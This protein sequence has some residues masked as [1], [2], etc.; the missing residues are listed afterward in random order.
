[1]SKRDDWIN[2]YPTYLICILPDEFEHDF[3]FEPFE[4]WKYLFPVFAGKL[5]QQ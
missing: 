5:L 3:I 2:F 4:I 1:M